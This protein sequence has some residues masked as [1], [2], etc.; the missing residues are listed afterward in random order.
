MERRARE[1][2]EELD[3]RANFLWLQRVAQAQA[4]AE[5]G[6]FD[7]ALFEVNPVNPLE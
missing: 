3:A 4:E 6:K 2:R 7:R 5:S 1:R